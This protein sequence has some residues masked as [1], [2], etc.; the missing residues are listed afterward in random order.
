MTTSAPSWVRPG[1]KV[2]RVGDGGHRFG[3]NNE[4]LP[5]FGMVYTIRD[6]FDS[7]KYTDGKKHIGIRL[8]EIVNPP[9]IYDGFSTPLECAFRWVD[10]KP[11]Y[12]KKT[13]IAIFTNIL[14]SVNAGKVLE[15]QE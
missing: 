5:S 10:F 13:D 7:F 15:F 1:Q 14:N 12:E 3:L 9:C 2:T 11:V 6:V 4:I 8:V